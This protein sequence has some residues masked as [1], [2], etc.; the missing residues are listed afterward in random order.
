[1]SRLGFSITRIG[2]SY[3]CA[4]KLNV[5]SKYEVPDV[6]YYGGEDQFL[7]ADENG[8]FRRIRA[9]DC[10]LGEIMDYTREVKIV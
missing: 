4:F 9:A 8:K 6:A 3:Y 2:S 5:E 7:I 10:K 1:M